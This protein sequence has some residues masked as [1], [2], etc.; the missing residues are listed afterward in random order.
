M[1]AVAR[2]RPSLRPLGTLDP[3]E[4]YGGQVFHDRLLWQGH[5]C[6]D[7][8][9]YRLDVHDA[10][11][12]LLASTAVPHTLEFLHA[13]GPRT[14][15]AV[16]KHDHGPG[17]WRTFHSTVRFVP[18]DAARPP[19]LAVTTRAMPR[20]LQ[21]EQ[22]GGSP[23][24]MFFNDPGS[25]KVVH[26]RGWWGRTLRPDLHLPGT[27]IHR[28]RHLFVLERNDI[29]P[30]HETIARID[31]G[32]QTV[33]R[34]FVEPRERITALVDVAGSPWIAAA[35]AW[36]DR[37]LLVDRATNRLAATLPAP[38]MPVDLATSGTRLVVL[39]IE[40]QTL[41]FFDLVAAGLPLVAEWDLSG[42]NVRRAHPRG[43]HVDPATG[44]VFI[45]SAFH[46][47]IV[48]S[49]AGVTLAAEPGRPGVRRRG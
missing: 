18:G 30:G 48:G 22:F 36:A 13:F 25:R 29:R 3:R 20:R 7:V 39:A 4:V 47:A 33:E 37:V 24:A 6:G 9:S 41:R 43:L 16:G 1:P 21:V 34:T 31:L 42:M 2:V 8:S 27:M 17:G 35:E 23:G 12:G 14:V 28:G 32:S 45:R 10:A 44:T 40:S 46:P 5:S 15:L 38:G 11:G 49:T 26:W 19:R